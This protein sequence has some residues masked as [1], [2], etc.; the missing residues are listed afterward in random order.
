MIRIVV[1]ALLAINLL[2]FGW[3]RWVGGHG[4]ELTAVAANLPPRPAKPAPPAA[5]PPCATVGPFSDEMQALQAQQKLE[6]AG[7]GVVRRQTS[8]NTHEG[9]WVYVPNT[10]VGRQARTLN[11]IRRAG[12]SDAFAMPD[13]PEFRVSVGIF[14]EEDRAEDRAARVQQLKLD[15]TVSERSHEQHVFWFDV[16][17]VARETLGDG[18]L[19]A[20]GIVLDKLRVEACPAAA[21]APVATP[22]AIIPP[23]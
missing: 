22:A 4:A 8:E 6:A 11:A 12:I 21:P 3:S 5:P 2:Y 19:A 17:G 23:P 13:D 20:A 7:W 1:L 9:W 10:D 18:R 16:P 14:S 15:A